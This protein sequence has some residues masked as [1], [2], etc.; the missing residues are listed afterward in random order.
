MCRHVFQLKRTNRVQ[1]AK[2]RCP[3]DAGGYVRINEEWIDIEGLI[4]LKWARTKSW[5]K[6]RCKLRRK[7]MKQSDEGRERDCK[8]SKFNIHPHCLNVNA[9]VDACARQTPPTNTTRNSFRVRPINFD[10]VKRSATSYTLDMLAICFRKQCGRGTIICVPRN[11]RVLS[12]PN[13]FAF[14][15]FHEKRSNNKLFRA[16]NRVRREKKTFIEIM[17]DDDDDEFGVCAFLFCNAVM[18]GLTNHTN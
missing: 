4:S 2:F 9:D 8:Q 1:E 6:F 13:I 7:C 10:I 15:Q 18:H 3:G 5:R 14:A 16:E 17:T 12:H 11:R